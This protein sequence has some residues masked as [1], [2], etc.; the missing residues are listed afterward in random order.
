[1]IDDPN[2]DV[3]VGDLTS[4]ALGSGARKNSGK[5]Q[6]GLLPLDLILTVFRRHSE[7][8]PDLRR[9]ANSVLGALGDWQRFGSDNWLEFALRLSERPTNGEHPLEGLREA[10]QVL[11]Y[12]A[13]KYAPWNWAKGMPYSVP[14]NCAIRHL[15]AI[16]RGE[17]TDPESGCSHW[18]HVQANLLMLL[19]YVERYGFDAG[20]N[21]MPRAV[22]KAPCTI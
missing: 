22:L 17:E 1:M 14:F 18:G 5:L 19:L 6:W 16:H 2:N 15:L 3:A 7:V 13:S 12:G 4:S 9:N 11:E 8:H 21:D 20:L 10:V